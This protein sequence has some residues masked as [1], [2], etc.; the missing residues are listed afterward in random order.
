MKII[1]GLGNPGKEYEKTKHNLGF[2]FLDY[3]NEKLNL[4]KFKKFKSSEILESSING[5]KVIFAKPQTFMNL[6]GKAVVELKQFYKVENKDILIVY[7]DFDIL[8]GSVRFREKGRA[9]THNGMKDIIQK[10]SSVEIPRLRIGT[11]GLKKEKEEVISFVLSR[12]SN[13]E[14]EETN[15]I[16][17]D[18]YVKLQEFLDK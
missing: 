3:L 17:E 2:M 12:F 8:F 1:V 14:L 15:Q 13:S 18:A 6:S 10:I 11:G 7:D 5:E 4:G 9:G 16:F